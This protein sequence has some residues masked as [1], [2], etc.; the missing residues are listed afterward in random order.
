[1]FICCAT[2]LDF[3]SLQRGKYIFTQ[4]IIF[5]LREK[6]NP[7]ARFPRDH[8]FSLD[9]MSSWKRRTILLMLFEG[10]SDCVVQI[11]IS[12]ETGEERAWRK[13]SVGRF[14]C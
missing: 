14:S 3:Y 10:S 1:M 7:S 13:V 2:S 4:V 9:V 8:E 6:K 11:R 12:I 5:Q